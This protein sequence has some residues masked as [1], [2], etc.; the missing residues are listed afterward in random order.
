MQKNFAEQGLKTIL[1]TTNEQQGWLIPQYI[2]DFE[3]KLLADKINK[4]SWQPEPNYSESYLKIK[5][6]GDALSLANTCWFTCAVFPEWGSRKG[7]S[8]NYYIDMGK[9][10]YSI[11]LEHNEIPTIYAMQ[12]YF[13]F[14]AETAYTAIRHYGDFRNMWD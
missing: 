7:I 14:L 6:P 11:V 9:S 4:P 12:K 10:C 1:I 5:S 13:E 2:V 8:L 3:A